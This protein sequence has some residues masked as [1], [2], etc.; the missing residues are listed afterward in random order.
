MATGDNDLYGEAD[1]VYDLYILALQSHLELWLGIIAANIPILGPLISR[2]KWSNV[3][4][5]LSG[6]PRSNISDGRSDL[7]TFGRFGVNGRDTDHFELLTDRAD[8]GASHGNIMK[9]QDF[10]VSV[11]QSNEYG[12]HRKDFGNTK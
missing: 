11:E 12:D 4:E 8:A 7:R 2:L 1:M 10:H 9:R 3:R 6:S 5:Y